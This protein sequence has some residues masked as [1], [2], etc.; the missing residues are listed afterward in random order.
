[1]ANEV[2]SGEITISLDDDKVVLRSTLRAAKAVSAGQGGFVG[3]LQRISQFELAAYVSVVA[4]GSGRNEKEIE[5]AVFSA[6]IQSLAEP[7]T[8]YVAL[9]MNGGR[10]PNAKSENE[11]SGKP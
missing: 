3:A 4:A 1:M 11:A 7:L 2:N 6:G 9:L 8:K 5:D 10:D